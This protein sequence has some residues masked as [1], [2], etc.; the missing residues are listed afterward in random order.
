VCEGVT[1]ENCGK[2]EGGGNLIESFVVLP[3]NIIEKTVN[4]VLLVWA[5]TRREKVFGRSQEMYT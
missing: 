3:T 1:A 4:Y 5:R 2:A